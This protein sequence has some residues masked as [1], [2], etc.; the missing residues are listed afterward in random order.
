MTI[1][2]LSHLFQS[3]KGLVICL[4]G[5]YLLPIQAQ[6]TLLPCGTPNWYDAWRVRYLLEPARFHTSAK[7]TPYLL[8][9]QLYL[10]HASEV[11]PHRSY[12][13]SVILDALCQLNEDFKPTGIRFYLYDSIRTVASDA[14][15]DHE[16]ILSGILFMQR[17]QTD[18]VINCYIVKGAAGTCGYN[19]PYAGI[20]LNYSCLG[21][22]QHTWTHEI[23]HH[24][25]LPHTFLGWEGKEYHPDS[26]TPQ[27]VVYDYTLF[28]DSL[29]TDTVIYDTAEVELV[30]RSNCHR[31]ADGFCDTPPDYLSYRWE[32]DD[33]ARST[34]AL[35]DFKGQRFYADGSLYMSYALDECQS[36]FS[37]EQTALMWAT[38]QHK[39]SYLLRHS[40]PTPRPIEEEPMLLAPLG[41]VLLDED[42]SVAFRW[43]AVDHAE[44]YV[45]EVAINRSFSR[46]RHR[47][48][49]P[50]TSIALPIGSSRKHWW[51]VTAF[52]RTHFCVRRTP[53]QSFIPIS[54]SR[55]VLPSYSMKWWYTDG[56]L[57]MSA[58]TGQSL[59]LQLLTTH[60]KVLFQKQ[61]FIP[62]GMHRVPIPPIVPGLYIL[63]ACSTKHKGQCTSYPI[64][65]N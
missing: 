59:W 9:I 37:Y 63:K 34:F 11:S 3:R 61:Y 46:L 53:P 22:G 49:T 48:V 30:D 24:L 45:V 26:P 56:Y 28:K 1:A 13:T 23:G 4:L 17:H 32:C 42:G 21:K 60:G 33:S 2:V 54:T 18:G 39:R 40:T 6:D 57:H 27:K 51:R 55:T 52:N 7:D 43:S 31:A 10:I 41:N 14:W 64:V 15:T 5:G 16:D 20:T 38:I 62:E 50:D 8:P 36:R 25:S 35:Q 47:I 58:S 65:V 12:S 29:I 44:W 19:I